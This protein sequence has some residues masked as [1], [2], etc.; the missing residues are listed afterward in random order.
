ML[1]K[2]FSASHEPPP[3]Q[4]LRRISLFSHLNGAELRT[5]NNRVHHRTYLKEEVIFDEGEEGQAIYFIQSGSVLI[6]RQGRPQD[7]AIATLDAGQCFGEMA[8]LDDAPRMAQVRAAEDCE[9]VVLFREDFLDLLNT[10]A[11]I[12]AK[13]S[14]AL[15]HM[16]G[17][18][19][20]ATVNR[21]VV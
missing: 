13:L 14:L 17:N 12:G 10:H 6:C 9:L 7:G 5:V 15:A 18:R 4:T 3:I 20:R 19:L 8:L 1:R 16:L 21:F 11:Q 2:L